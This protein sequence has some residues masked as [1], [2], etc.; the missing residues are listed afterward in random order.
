[1]QR[2]KIFEKKVY[3]NNKRVIKRRCPGDLD[4]RPGDVKA[5]RLL[6]RRFT[7]RAKGNRARTVPT[8]KKQK[9]PHIKR[10]AFTICGLLPG[11][12]VRL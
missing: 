8:P 9:N 10:V 3:N 2:T 12:G 5:A 11:G 4:V 1:M 6:Y 7:V